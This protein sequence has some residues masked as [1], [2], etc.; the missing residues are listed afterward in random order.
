[1]TITFEEV[2]SLASVWRGLSGWAG[3]DALRRSAEY[4]PPEENVRPPVFRAIPP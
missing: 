2:Q 1:M 4:R 3:P